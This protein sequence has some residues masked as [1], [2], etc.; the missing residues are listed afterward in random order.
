M[1]ISIELSCHPASVKASF[2][3]CVGLINGCVLLKGFKPL[4][5]QLED[6]ARASFCPCNLTI[7]QPHSSLHNLNP[8]VQ[9]NPT[10][11]DFR[12]RN[13]QLGLVFFL[14]NDLDFFFLLLAD[15]KRHEILLYFMMI[16]YIG[17]LSGQHTM[18][19]WM[20]LHMFVLFFVY[21]KLYMVTFVKQSLITLN[22]HLHSVF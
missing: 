9:I 3:V 16:F 4:T 12:S 18:C 20:C 6:G 21:V 14:Q 22:I 10:Q 8:I 11:S 17:Y 7:R 15:Q 2:W 13:T 1:L 19:V 5:K